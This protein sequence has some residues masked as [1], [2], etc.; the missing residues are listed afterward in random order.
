MHPSSRRRLFLVCCL[1]R[2]LDLFSRK[3]I[4]KHTLQLIACPRGHF[5]SEN[6][7]NLLMLRM[8]VLIRKDSCYVTESI[9]LK[10]QLW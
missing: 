7:K 8:S 10:K 2:I 6:P 1:D 9:R 3:N 4:D 5:L